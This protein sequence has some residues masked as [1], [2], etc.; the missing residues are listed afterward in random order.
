MD[1]DY[2]MYDVPVVGPG[3]ITVATRRAQAMRQWCVARAD[4]DFHVAHGAIRSL[5]ST[6]SRRAWQQFQKCVADLPGEVHVDA[7]EE[8]VLR[9]LCPDHNDQRIAVHALPG[10]EDPLLCTLVDT[11]LSALLRF[12]QPHDPLSWHCHGRQAQQQWFLKR[13]DEWGLSPPGGQVPPHARMVPPPAEVVLWRPG[14]GDDTTMLD[15]RAKETRRRH[16]TVVVDVLEYPLGRRRR[17]QHTGPPS[18][19][20][21]PR[22]RRQPPHRRSSPPHSHRSSS[23]SITCKR[24]RCMI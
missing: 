3:P 23:I 21:K 14:W 15:D 24:R 16:L 13:Q 17:V 7:G 19:P 9:P 1:A 18:P 22:D 20:A 4:H 11:D 10:G 2:V 6:W 5:T 8:L 12:L